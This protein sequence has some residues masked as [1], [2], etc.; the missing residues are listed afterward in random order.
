MYY[1]IMGGLCQRKLRC[2]AK[3]QKFFKLT[4]ILPREFIYKEWKMR[5]KEVRVWANETGNEA[6]QRS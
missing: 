5:T 2:G 3:L 4:A 6:N 1:Y